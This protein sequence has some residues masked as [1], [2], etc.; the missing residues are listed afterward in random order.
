M[1][2]VQQPVPCRPA[3]AVTGWLLGKGTLQPGA[4]RAG[5]SSVLACFG[6]KSQLKT[7]LLKTCGSV[8]PDFI[9]APMLEDRWRKRLFKASDHHLLQ[10]RQRGWNIFGRDL[11]SNPAWQD[12]I[13]LLV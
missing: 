7:I 13:L 12:H 11:L 10:T 5:S 2:Q 3:P 8:K 9:L 6:R 1:S 4:S